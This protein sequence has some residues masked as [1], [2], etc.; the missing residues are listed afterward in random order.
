MTR[1]TY[2][3]EC[4]ETVYVDA[5]AR[6]EAKDHLSPE[7]EYE[8]GLVALAVSMTSETFAKHRR[9]A[10][11]VTEGHFRDIRI[12]DEFGDD[13][14]FVEVAQVR[15]DMGLDTPGWSLMRS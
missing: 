8:I 10:A 12:L 5:R 13:F 7:D 1:E 2:L 14:G 15:Q 6:H 11:R 4:M 3:C 9:V